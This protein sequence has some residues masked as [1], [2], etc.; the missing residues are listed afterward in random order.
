MAAATALGFTTLASTPRADQAK[1][2]SAPAPVE[3]K[4]PA[5]IGPPAP[6]AGPLEA[7]ADPLS[8]ASL[9]GGHRLAAPAS[10]RA[11]WQ[12]A[13]ANAFTPMAPRATEWREEEF[14][15][16]SVVDGRTLEAGGRRIRLVGLDLPLPEQMCRTLD[17][18]LE[19]CLQRAATQLELLT[20]WRQVTCHYRVEATGDAI[21]RC[22]LGFSDLTERMIKTGYVWP[23]ADLPRRSES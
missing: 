7:P 9:F 15:Q 21:G 19:P 12:E 23:S 4:D 11:A 3:P 18:R 16:V 17:G 13:P 8:P 10:F 14:A 5:R 20:R 2:V 6:Q 1:P 22:R